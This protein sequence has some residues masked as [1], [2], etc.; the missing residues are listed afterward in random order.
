M[1]RFNKELEQKTSAA[2]EEQQARPW[3]PRAAPQSKTSMRP[4]ATDAHPFP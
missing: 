1:P 4:A 2:L 3:L